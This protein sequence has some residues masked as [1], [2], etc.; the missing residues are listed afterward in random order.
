MRLRHTEGGG[1]TRNPL[2]RAGR[3]RMGGILLYLSRR[4][5]QGAQ[6]YWCQIEIPAFD[7]PTSGAMCFAPLSTLV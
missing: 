3:Y 1:N 6:R 4:G 5:G 2:R 7:P